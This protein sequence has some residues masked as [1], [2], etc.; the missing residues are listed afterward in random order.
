MRYAGYINYVSY[1]KRYVWYFD[2]G[3]SREVV[4]GHI[5]D[6]E[7]HG[8]IFYTRVTSTFGLL[9]VDVPLWDSNTM[10]TGVCTAAGRR[11]ID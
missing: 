6:E 11:R 1:Q 2:V 9:D 8:T 10:A 5:D 3:Y 7:S 4:L